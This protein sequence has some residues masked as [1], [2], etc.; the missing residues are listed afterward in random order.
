M[1]VDLRDIIPVEKIDLK[2]LTGR[3]IAIDAYN[4][5]YQFLAIIRQPDGTPLIDSKGRVTSHL[6]GLFYRTINLLESGIKPIYVFDGAPPQIKS[7]TL[8]ERK[9]IRL[10]AEEKWKKALME[11]HIE[12]ARVYAQAA[13]SLTEEMVEESK[14][15]LEAIGVPYVQAPSEGEAQAAYLTSK[16]DA[17][18]SGSQD[19]DSILF[20]SPRLIRNLTI[21][22]RRK[23]PRKNIY[24]KIDVELIESDQIYRELQLTREQLI[25]LAILI[26]TD[27]NEGVKGIGPRT[28]LKLIKK[29][30]KL[31]EI[32]KA[33][34]LSIDAPID[35]IRALFL[36]PNVTNEYTLRWHPPSDDD[37]VEI[38]CNE[39]DFS[40]ERVSR[41]LERLNKALETSKQSSLESW[42]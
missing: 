28:A 8:N 24:I 7:R 30:G 32:I 3:K 10:Q 38:L 33:K 31:E 15:L 1:G 23:L 35:E 29:Y 11:G 39:H 17:W 34:N 18:A 9:Q 40:Y 2:H 25:D 42:F 4:A 21:T 26:G 37:V 16:G 27:Y 19:W 13:L 5:L 14:K 41:G 36:K 22:G 20:G 12:E 6:S